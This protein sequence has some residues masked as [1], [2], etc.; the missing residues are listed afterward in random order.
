[1]IDAGTVARMTRDATLA[2]SDI[3]HSLS[4]STT[5]QAASFA[6]PS[7]GPTLEERL[8]DVERRLAAAG[9]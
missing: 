9:L 3:E 2:A 6:A 5:A 8:A 7:E 1:M 4:V